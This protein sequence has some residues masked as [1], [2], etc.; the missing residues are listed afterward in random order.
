VRRQV[1]A[2]LRGWYDGHRDLVDNTVSLIGSAAVT[3]GLGFGFWWVAARLFAPEAIGLA[4]AAVSAML[5]LSTM[6]VVGLDALLLSEI[7]R[8]RAGAGRLVSTA[9]ATALAASA[10]LGLAFAFIAPSFS[11]NLATFFAGPWTP[12][13]FALGVGVTGATFVFDRATVGFLRGGI[14]FRRNVWFSV[15]KLALLPALLLW[16]PLVASADVAIYAVWAATTV[17]SLLLVLPAALRG[18]RLRDLTPRWGLLSRLRVDALRHHLLNVVQHG[19]GLAMPVL[20]VALFPAA[21]SGAFYVTWMLITFA[22]VVPVHLTT[23]LHT[24]GVRDLV[25]LAEKVRT[26]LRLS[27]FAAVA[28]A[29]TFVALAEPVLRLFGEEYAATA[30]MALRVLALTVFPMT[31]KVHFFALARIHGFTGRAAWIGGLFGVFELLAAA[32]GGG[33]GGLL[34][35]GSLTS[36]SLFLLVAM[37]IESAALLP[38]VLRSARVPD[39]T[40]P[41]ARPTP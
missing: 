17:V 38:S 18:T 14:Q 39:A 19:P 35:E 12:L 28:I 1:G 34:S 15:L 26:T 36:M 10:L 30:S 23:V 37:L 41:S 13:G 2:R 22:Q 16:A 20:V 21:T 29:V 5:L 9:V 27:L 8:A 32:V 6:G 24:V 3:S 7:P 40:A 25:Q 31:V 4:S 11:P 33:A